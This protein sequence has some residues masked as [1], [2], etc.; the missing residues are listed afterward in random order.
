MDLEANGVCPVRGMARNCRSPADMSRLLMVP[1]E[2]FEPP[3]FGLQN[4]CTTTVLS[5]LSC[6][7]TVRALPD[8]DQRCKEAGVALAPALIE[9]VHD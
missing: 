8:R 5:R 9:S 3:T 2:G 1:A 7:N 4:R 6:H